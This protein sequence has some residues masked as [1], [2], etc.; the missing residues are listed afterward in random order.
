MILAL[1]S[2]FAVGSVALIQDGR[3]LREIRVE[4]PRGRGG[5]IFG[6]LQDVLRDADGLRRVVVGTGP[7]SYNGIRSAIAAGWGIATARKIPLTGVSSL[8]GLADGEYCAAGDARRGQYFFAR[9][10][11]GRFL[12]GPC[13]VDADELKTRAGTGPVLTPAEVPFLPGATLR[14]PEAARL[15]FLGAEGDPAMPEPIYLKPAFIT[16]PRTR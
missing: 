3:I 13:L 10:R 15:A 2:S 4:T 11:D 1:D 7:G 6:A 16:A 8:L 9:V 14:M 5:A 12:E